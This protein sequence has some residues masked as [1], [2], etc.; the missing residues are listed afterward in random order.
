MLEEYLKNPLCNLKSYIFKCKQFRNREN[1]RQVNEL[2]HV[3]K[4]LIF[5]PYYYAFKLPDFPKTKGQ[6]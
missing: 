6:I 2:K 3:L 1:I 5:L 4:S